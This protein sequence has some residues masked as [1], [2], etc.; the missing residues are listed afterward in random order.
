LAPP[1][2]RETPVEPKTTNPAA[3][4]PGA[5]SKPK[6]NTKKISPERW[7]KYL[8]GTLPRPVGEDF[9]LFQVHFDT[10]SNPCQDDGF[11]VIGNWKSCCRTLNMK[12]L[13]E[14]DRNRNLQLSIYQGDD[15][16]ARIAHNFAQSN[17]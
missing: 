12:L 7:I 17:N 14:A 8:D 2:S 11:D 6:M 1:V 16:Q 9:F 3:N 15:A 10:P 4:L 5:S 13:T